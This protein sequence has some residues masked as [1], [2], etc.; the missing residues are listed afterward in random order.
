VPLK[1]TPSRRTVLMLPEVT[2]TLKALQKVTDSPFCFLTK[3]GARLGRNNARVMVLRKCFLSAGLATRQDDGRISGARINFHGLRSLAATLAAPGMNPVT[4]QKDVRMV[5]CQHR[6]EALRTRIGCSPRA[7]TFRNAKR[8]R[9]IHE[10]VDD[11]EQI[12]EGPQTLPYVLSQC[13]ALARRVQPLEQLE[14][15][16]PVRRTGTSCPFDDLGRRNDLYPDWVEFGE[17]STTMRSKA[18]V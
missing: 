9:S 10:A 4:L 8:S 5:E 17:L 1:T 13:R 3:S 18:D 16:V 11:S 14:S 7:G 15:V 12:N 6:L 2:N